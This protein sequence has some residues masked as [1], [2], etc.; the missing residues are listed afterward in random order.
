MSLSAAEVQPTRCGRPFAAFLLGGLLLAS[1]PLAAQ[2]IGD[3]VHVQG[4]ASAQRPG[5]PARFLQKGDALN[6][7]DVINT[8]AR[9]YA[10][11]QLKDDSKFT[12]RPDTTFAI[13]EYRQGTANDGML[14]RLLKGGMRAV[15]GLMAKRNPQ[16]VRIN[17]GTATIGIRGTSFDA[18]L[19]GAECAQEGRAGD[20]AAVSLAQQEA[21]VARIAVTFGGVSLVGADG[22]A[23][24]AVKGA[25]LANGE[26]VRTQKDAYAVVAFRDRTVVS[27][28]AESEFKLEN[29]RFSAA[30]PASDNFLVR[31][32]KGGARALTGALGRRD[33][34]AVR[35]NVGTATIGIRGTGVDGRLALD[36][37]AGACNE[38]A[39]VYTWDGAVSF[40][41]GGRSLLV[42]KD[43]AAVHNAARDRF[44][45][46][47]KV[48]EFFITETAPRP[49]AL[50]IDFDNLFGTAALD[51]S[52]PGLY[53]LTRDGH[54]ELASEGRSIDLGPGDSGYTSEGR[55]PV[56]LTVTPT[57]MLFD[58]VP[59]PDKFDPSTTRLIDL[60]NM[61]GRPGD[62]I[63]EI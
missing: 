35:F 34:K 33:P 31:I 47:D 9:G 22:Q 1:A 54:I 61:G 60:L 57:F 24:P 48:P 63:C 52:P 18:R 12:L 49:D 44:L 53:V 10:V 15:T 32:V 55:P 29:V 11:I 59:L 16:S 58:P 62:L 5:E 25:P 28:I 30:Q 42:E 23:R 21:I 2:P 13:P 8:A 17:A 39:F 41:V 36:C 14:V 50:T 46:L 20:R 6:Q 7:G 40:D 27:V 43:R 4:I 51:G 56:R 3:V 37:V 45:V 19:C 38:A 26:S